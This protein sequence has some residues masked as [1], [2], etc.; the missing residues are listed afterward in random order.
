MANYNDIDMSKWKDY[1]DIE[2]DSLWLINKRDKT[3]IHKIKYNGNFVPQIPH[4]LFQRYTKSGDWV[5]D[6]FMGSGTSLIEAQRMDRNSIGIELN[7]QLAKEVITKLKIE[8]KPNIIT[9]VLTGDSKSINL[10]DSFSKWG[11]NKVQFIVFHPPYWDIIKFSDSKKDL[12][13]SA[14]LESFLSQMS[15]V[16]D[17]TIKHLE[18]GRYCSLV[19]ADKYYKSEI[20]PLGFYLMQIFMTKKL[21]LKAIIVKNISNETE[22]KLGKQGIWRYRALSSDFYVFKHEYIMI[23]KN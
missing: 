1:D 19:I 7:R 15:N 11:I 22:G 8:S 13:N 5:L 2:T 9:D 18:K 14:S 3:G 10:L 17:N 20:I 6:P 23:F 12:S 21:K 4:Q 16:I